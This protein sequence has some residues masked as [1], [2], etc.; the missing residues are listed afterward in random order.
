ME[1]LLYVW[2]LN[3]Q[4]NITWKLVQR[5]D[6]ENAEGSAEKTKKRPRKA[7]R[8]PGWCA[9]CVNPALFVQLV[10]A[11]LRLSPRLCVSAV[12]GQPTTRP[13]V[14]NRSAPVRA[15]RGW[16]GARNCGRRLPGRATSM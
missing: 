8:L 7:N 12:N 3:Q 9:E 5:R 10:F 14:R 16:R 4:Q 1:I 11:S 15:S 2:V 13:A 6:A